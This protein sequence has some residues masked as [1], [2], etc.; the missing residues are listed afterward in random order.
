MVFENIK[1]EQ[2]R[3]LAVTLRTCGMA[4]SDSEA[5][6]MAEEMSFTSRKVQKAYDDQDRTDGFVEKAK[7]NVDLPVDIPGLEESGN[8]VKE[9]EVFIDSSYKGVFDS[10][11]TVKELMAEEGEE[12]L[13]SNSVDE[14]KKDGALESG[15]DEVVDEELGVEP[16]KGGLEIKEVDDKKRRRGADDMAESKIDLSDV[17]NFNKK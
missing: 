6:R 8:V 1:D 5:V 13:A 3:K 11:K 7:E 10:N 15:S 12:D 4:S 9:Q 14:S 16:E 17:F 2:V